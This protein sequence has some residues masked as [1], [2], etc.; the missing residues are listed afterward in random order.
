MAETIRFSV[1]TP[2]HRRPQS[3]LRML[4]AISRQDYPSDQ[5]EV[6]VIDDGGDGDLAGVLQARHDPFRLRV[7][8]QAKGGP[9]VARNRGVDEASEAFALFLDDDVLP[10]RSLMRNHAESHEARDVVVIG[11]LLAAS[12]VR[13]APWTAWEWATLQEQYREMEAG[14]WAPTPRQFYTG[15]ASVRIDHVRAVGG[16]HPDFRR[17]EDV[18][19]AWRLH[20]RGLRF[21]FNPRAGAEHLASRSFEAWLDAAHEYGRTDVMLERIRTGGDLPGWV[22]KEFRNRNPYTRLVTRAILA[23]PGLWGPISQC[24]HAAAWAATRCGRDAV[25]GSV[26]SA[27]FTSAYWRGVATSLGR[28]QSLALTAGGRA[29]AFGKGAA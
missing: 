24:G 13:P 28:S 1:I 7:V 15:N 9:A 17:G 16:F 26:C 8:T 21:I 29:L 22:Q 2:T 27:L 19:L 18:E 23:K 20:D 4:D 11:P 12:G 25:A 3:L 14:K 6:I 5:F 10:S